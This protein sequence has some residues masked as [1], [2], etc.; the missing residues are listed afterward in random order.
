MGGSSKTSET[1]VPP[2]TPDSVTVPLPT[3]GDRL[4]ERHTI[5]A[6]SNRLRHGNRDELCPPTRT[7]PGS[8]PREGKWIKERPL[9][10]RPM[11]HP[12]VRDIPGCWVTKGTSEIILTPKL[13]R[14]TVVWVSGVEVPMKSQGTFS[15][16][17][18]VKRDQR[19]SFVNRGNYYVN[20][21]SHSYTFSLLQLSTRVER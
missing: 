3:V 17:S 19:L 20:I 13:G 10:T 21:N 7:T 16:T 11:W 6:H 12:H 15:R 1:P 9:Y 8:S 2:S 5:Q 4:L 14:L 18:I